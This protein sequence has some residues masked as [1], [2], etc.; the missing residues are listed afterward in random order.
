MAARKKRININLLIKQQ[1]ATD[2]TGQIFSWALT[3]GRYI[4]IIT[5]IFVLSVFFLRFKLDR[6]YTDLKE[7][8]TQKQ[9][10][11]ESVSD[12]ETEIRMIQSRL[13]FIKQL[14]TNQ[15]GILKILSYLSDRVPSDI[16]FINLSLTTN[17]LSF[18]AVVENLRSFSYFLSQLQQD[19]KF[20]DVTLDDIFRRTDGRIEF[21]INTN[22]DI[23]NF[24]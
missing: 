19:N 1:V 22:I 5:Q 21:R 13:T 17:K 7:S 11:I 20:S 15:Q 2:F 10:L 18:A 4:I 9:A 24:K 23:K 16:S 12:L 14:S 6:D 3:Y 8:V